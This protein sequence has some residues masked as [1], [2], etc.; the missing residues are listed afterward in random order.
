MDTDINYIIQESIKGDKNSQEIL[1]NKLHPLI[2]KNIYKYYQRDDSLIE[3]LVQEG[4]IIILN[5]LKTFNYKYDVHFLGYVK[6]KL[7]FFY[8]NYY[9][10]MK[11]QRKEI[12][13]NQKLVDWNNGV[14]L[15]S[16]ILY[17][18]NNT[19]DEIYK[20]DEVSE[21]LENIKKLSPKEQIVLNMYYIDELSMLDISIKLNIAYRTVIGRKYNA[22]KK[23]KKMM[24]GEK[25][26]RTI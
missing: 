26:G 20:R 12:S 5:S 15:E 11:N 9:R 23:L 14:E 24:D 3:D 10:N 16:I 6:M 13:L 2:Y 19:I 21:I 25:N 4:Y 1:M 22:I 7:E 8:K 18:T 17:D